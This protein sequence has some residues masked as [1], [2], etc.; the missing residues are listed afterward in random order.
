M[1]NR[2][3][4][5]T[6]L[7]FL[8]C[9]LVF[10]STGVESERELA[11]LFYDPYGLLGR[12]KPSFV[13]ELDRLFAAVGARVTW[14]DPNPTEETKPPGARPEAFRA[15]LFP[16][17][18][19]R[20]NLHPGVMG[21]TTGSGGADRVV[22]LFYPAVV[23]TLQLDDRPEVLRSGVG[24][25]LCARAVARVLAHEL[26]HAAAPELPHA[27]TGLLK[28]HLTRRALMESNLSLDETAATALR[29][30]ILRWTSSASRRGPE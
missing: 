10:G 2:I 13:S 25:D 18:A 24:A 11:L 7:L 4:K 12:S 20:M 5:S 15:I 29:A 6:C 16:Q 14:L 1:K 27:E 26:V 17:E 30:G 3:F 23:R 9:G 22:Y 21:V 28:A 8:T 19:S